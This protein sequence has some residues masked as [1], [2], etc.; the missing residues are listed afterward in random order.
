MKK[1]LQIWAVVAAALS[2]AACT[3]DQPDGSQYAADPELT[4]STSTI[5]FTQQGGTAWV[6]VEDAL[7]AE[8]L[9][10]SEKPWA[11]LSVDGNRVSV[12]VPANR[13]LDSRYST[14]T[15][16]SGSSSAKIQVI[17]F[18][19]TSDK[20]W[21][22]EYTFPYAGGT[23]VLKH[24]RDGGFWFDIDVDWL[25][26]EFEEGQ[27]TITAEKNPWNAVRTGTIDWKVEDESGSIAF[28][29]EANPS[30]R[31]PGDPEPLDFKFQSAWM[32]SYTPS[33]SDDTKAVIAVDASGE[34]GSYFMAIASKA[35]FVAAGSNHSDF[36]NKF[37]LAELAKAPKTYSGSASEEID[38]P[39][40]GDY[41][42][43][44]IGVNTA[45]E[46]NAAYSYVEFK[47]TK[48]LSP[49]EKWLGTWSVPRGDYVDTWTITE[50]VP[51]QSYTIVGIDGCD[52]TGQAPEVKI[53]ATF[54]AS[55]GSMSVATQACGT[56]TASSY[57]EANLNLYGI[58]PQYYYTGNYKIFTGTLNDDD[59]ATLTPGTVKSGS[60]TL[61][62]FFI[63]I[64]PIEGSDK[65]VFNNNVETPLPNTITHLSQGEGSGEGGGGGGEGGGSAYEKWLGSWSVDGGTLVISQDVANSSYSV[66]GFADFT[67]KAGFDAST[68][69]LLFQGQYLDEDDTYEY[70]FAGQDTDEYME[71]GDQSKSYLLARAS[72]SSDG[73]SASIVSHEYDAVYSGTTYHEKIAMMTIWGVPTDE[74]DEYV[75]TFNGVLQVNVPGT[76]TKAS[77]SN[78]VQ[79]AIRL[80]DDGSR[81]AAPRHATK[82]VEHRGTLHR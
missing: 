71:L 46:L 49:Y 41:I 45:G 7:S 21:P 79:R 12:T 3:T 24:D 44:V 28:T 31:N 53:V 76:M 50:N 62:G 16:A 78:V 11:T 1:Y 25:S 22:T 32:P 33:E 37:A 4:V 5:E 73:K 59:T 64:E 82:K 69:D 34:A 35:D 19:T 68:G 40:V 81:T 56:Y 36:L 42:L 70:Y 60:V 67:I 57:G 20:I 47:V 23:L 30:G 8:L 43:Y 48:A 2:T 51:G 27:I 14:I 9:A 63:L 65:Y 55:D 75:Y 58:G 26:A 77:G 17:Q 6:V 61:V 38:R 52:G 15:L 29:Q 39:A 80:S 10:G 74:E 66:S 13:S 72:L 54:D 18:G